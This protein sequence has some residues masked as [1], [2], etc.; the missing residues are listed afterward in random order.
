MQRKTSKSSSAEAIDWPAAIHSAL[1]SQRVRQVSYVPDAGHKRLIELCHSDKDMAAVP[2]T[3]E[4][5]GI[6]LAA[7]AWLG[8]ERAALLM[9]SSGVGNC[10]NALTLASNC[11]FPL[12]ILV[13]MRG[14]WGEFNPWQIPMGQAT[15]A[16]LRL[17][18]VRTLRLERAEEALTTVTAAAKLAFGGYGAVAVLIAQRMIGAKSFG[19]EP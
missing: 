16:T 12:L 4:E 6:A 11:G 13:T 7:G 15:P 3:I 9:Q 8:G 19:D 17:A 18:G 5:E 10:V 2:L 14:E 1:K